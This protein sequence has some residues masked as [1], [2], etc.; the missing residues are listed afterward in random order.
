MSVKN[1]QTAALARIDGWDSLDKSEVETIITNTELAIQAR[2]EE[3]QNKLTFG[4]A[5]LN[6]RAVLEPKRGMWMAYLTN[7][8]HMSVPTAYRY[9]DRYEKTEQKLPKPVI[10]L[11]LKMGYDLSPKAIENTRPPQTDDHDTIVRYLDRVTTIRPRAISIEKSSDDLLKEWLHCV[12]L[13]WD[14]LPQNQRSRANTLRT[15]IGMIMT[16]FGI[17]NPTTFDPV[18]IPDH[19]RVYRGR[20]SRDRLAGARNAAA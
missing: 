14:K 8:F 7:V 16:Q 18:A 4:K 12:I 9:I 2:R 6:V 5:L 1:P 13:G 20:P 3:M 15:F 11:A 17:S 19:L 10:N